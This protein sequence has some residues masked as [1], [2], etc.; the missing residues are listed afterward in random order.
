MHHPLQDS[1]LCLSA[2]TAGVAV[3]CREADE[4]SH[5]E[6]AEGIFIPFVV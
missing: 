1:L 4:D 2:A 3:G 6:A 5:H